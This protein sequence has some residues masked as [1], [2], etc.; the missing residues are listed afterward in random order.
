M[1]IFQKHIV[2]IHV[3]T[4]RRWT[5]AW[6]LN[7]IWF[8]HN[9][10]IIN[11]ISNTLFVLLFLFLLYPS[12]WPKFD[13]PTGIFFSFLFSRSCSSIVEHCY[14][15]NSLRKLYSFRFFI[16]YEAY[17]FCWQVQR[18]LNFL[19]ENVMNLI[20]LNYLMQHKSFYFHWFSRTINNLT[21]FFAR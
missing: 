14:N 10:A 3:N 12:A 17:Y 8:N 2:I 4:C 1:F 19:F 18:S 7:L 16:F 20:Q 9:I 6:Q 15:K 11:L 21:S 13:I 5:L